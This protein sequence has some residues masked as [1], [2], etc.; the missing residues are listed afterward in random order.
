MTKTKLVKPFHC[1][2]FR[3]SDL[4]AVAGT[5]HETDEIDERARVLKSGTAGGSDL[6]RSRPAGALAPPRPGAE[7]V[8]LAA[9]ATKESKAHEGKPSLLSVIL[10]PPLILAVLQPASSP[11]DPLGSRED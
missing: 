10:A 11:E 4:T 7:C 5:N 6:H 8:Y 2:G 9:M 1:F 3:I